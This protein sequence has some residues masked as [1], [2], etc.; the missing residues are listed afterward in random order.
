VDSLFSRRKVIA[1]GLRL[2]ATSALSRPLRAFPLAASG[3]AFVLTPELET[4]PFYIASELVRKDI[5][6][7][8]PGVPLRLHIRVIDATT[9][10]P[11]KN[12]AV[13]IWHCDAAGIYSGYTS[14][15]ADG[16][17]GPGGPSGPPPLDG[18]GHMPPPPPDHGPGGPP[19]MRPTDKETFLRGIQLTDADGF[20]EFQTIY[21]G[22]YV[23]RDIHIHTKV[24]VGGAVSGNIYAGGHISHTGQIAFPDDISDAVAK[25]APYS[26]HK[27]MRTRLDEDHVFQS[28]T[29]ATTM[30]QL[31]AVNAASLGDGMTGT[32]ALVVDPSAAPEPANP[33]MR[34]MGPPERS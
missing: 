32:I 28:H 31:S 6:E 16:F 7:S 29:D 17:G 23:S 18:N 4:G 3:S 34:P 15:N 27:T 8:K 20:V 26:H 22:W 25:I 21:P 10:K 30:L 13:D 9:Y 14:S 24:H 5:T 33:I 1:G 19:A 11:L 12:A 2:A